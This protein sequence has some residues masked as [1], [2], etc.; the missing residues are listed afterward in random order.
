MKQGGCLVNKNNQVV[1]DKQAYMFNWGVSGHHPSPATADTNPHER[2]SPHGGLAQGLEV[3]ARRELGGS[4]RD[5]I[6]LTGGASQELW[7]FMAGPAATPQDYVLRRAPEGDLAGMFNTVGLE[8]EAAVIRAVANQGVPVAPVAYV[9]VPGD[10]LGSGFIADRMGGEALGRRIVDSPAFAAVRPR[11]AA[12]CG[13]I[14][15]GIHATPCDTLPQLPIRDPSQ[16][17]DQAETQLRALDD[18]QP[19]FEAALVW[20]R[21]RCPSPT[22]PQLVHGDFRTG[23]FLLEPDGISAVL[24]WEGCHLGDSMEDLG[25]LCM[26][27]WRFG[28]LD[29]PVGGFGQRKD[30]FESYINASGRSVDLDR[31]G[32]W[33]VYG[34]LRWGLTCLA[35]ATAFN[36]GDRSVERGAVGRR[37]SEAGLELVHAMRREV[38][39]HA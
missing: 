19:I 22:P 7:A 23:N 31:V 28:H 37:A 6:R 13:R 27:I 39:S 8:N 12:D 16:S 34:I 25:W 29:R 4:A 36:R 3:V 14:L 26:P 9:L 38:R 17:I 18:A 2:L 21:A 20:L 33:E 32:F 30:L 10:S 5:L 11:L 35:M 24:D 1:D 15:A